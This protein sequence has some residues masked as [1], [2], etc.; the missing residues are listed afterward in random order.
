M[1]ILEKLFPWRR[2]ALSGREQAEWLNVVENL[3]LLAGMADADRHRLQELAARF[4]HAKTLEP[5]AGLTLQRQDCMRLALQA[6]LPILGLGLDWYRGWSAIVIYPAEFI[7][8][9]EEIDDS[10]VVHMHPEARSGEAWSQ[11]GVILSLRDIRAAGACD[12]YNVI[13]H[14]MAHKLDMLNGDSNGFPPLHRGMHVDDWSTAFQHAYQDMCNAVDAGENTPIDAYATDSPGECFAVFS[15]CFFER[16]RL[17][18]SRYPDVYRQ[19]SLFYR[20][21]P[22]LRLDK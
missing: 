21:D 5:V 4:L 15:E 10:G 9:V 11:G 12:G 7:P 18:Q 17:L 14:E 2:R 16:P 6:C 20:Q 19:L 22:A 13:I 3:P 8:T 1:N